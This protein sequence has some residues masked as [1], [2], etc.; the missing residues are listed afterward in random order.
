MDCSFKSFYV[1][2]YTFNENFKEN[3]ETTFMECQ[4]LKSHL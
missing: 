4:W 2:I 3:N 1:M